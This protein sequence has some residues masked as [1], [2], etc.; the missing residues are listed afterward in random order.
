MKFIHILFALAIVTSC[1]TDPSKKAKESKAEAT[2]AATPTA[3]GPVVSFD[4]LSHD[5]GTINEG[6]VVETVFTLTNTG[7]SDLIILNARGSCGC[8]VPD[9]PKDQP[10]AP[11]DSAEVTVKFDSNNKPNA[12]NR[13]VTFTTNTEKGREVVQI[14]TFV[15]PDPLKEQQ[16]EA[17]RQAMQANQ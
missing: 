17:R 12:N 4:K 9:Y 1:S 8:T 5:F 13:S 16:R 11:G 7:N 3:D 2:E 10:I 14:R 6:E 15:T